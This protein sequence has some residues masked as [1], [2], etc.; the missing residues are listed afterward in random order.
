MTLGPNF[1]LSSWPI[2]RYQ[3]PAHVPD[4]MAQASIA[5]FDAL[6]ARNQRFV[7]VFHGPEMPKDSKHFMKLYRDWF[8]RTRATQQRLCAGGIRIEPDA[9]RRTSFAVKA[10]SLAN[11]VFLPYPYRVVANDSDALTQAR[12]WL[13]D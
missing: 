11:K 10:L 4:D 2:A 9:R 3:M 7:L 12:A 6:L 1:D 8:K 5:E 13:K